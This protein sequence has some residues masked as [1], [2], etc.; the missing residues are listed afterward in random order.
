MN[1]SVVYRFNGK[2]VGRSVGMPF[3]KALDLAKSINNSNQDLTWSS[4]KS[5]AYVE[6]T[7]TVKHLPVTQPPY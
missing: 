7:Q 1:F 5:C 3:Q 2:E 4:Y 6:E